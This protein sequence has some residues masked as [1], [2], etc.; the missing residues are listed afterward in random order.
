[1]VALW[2]VN[3]C[4]VLANKHTF[5]VSCS[6]GV[7]GLQDLM[8]DDLR[9]SWCN[10]KRNKVHKECN[11][12]VSSWNHHTTPLWENCLLLNQSLNWTELKPV[13]SAKMVGDQSYRPLVGS[14]DSCAAAKLPYVYAKSLQSYLTVALQAPLSMGFSRQEYWS[15]LSCPSPSSRGSSQPRGLNPQFLRLLAG[16]FFTTSAT[17]K[18]SKF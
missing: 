7:P 10:K 9:W 3:D 6:S 4:S 14:R 12:L 17:W 8:P 13:P 18:A 5:T 11:T 16:R 1:M 15:G 2:W